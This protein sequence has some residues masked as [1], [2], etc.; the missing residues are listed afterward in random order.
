MSAPD[1]TRRLRRLPTEYR[2][3][4]LDAIEQ[5]FSVEPPNRRGHFTV[6]CPEGRRV[7]WLSCS[8]RPNRRDF[9]NLRAYLRRAGFDG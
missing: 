2:D 4:M 7:A 9:Y 8:P 1:V 3:L 6:R 5:G